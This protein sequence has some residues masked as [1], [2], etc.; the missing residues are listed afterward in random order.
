MQAQRGPFLIL[1]Y[2]ILSYRFLG[3]LWGRS[4]PPERFCMIIIIHPT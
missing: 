3:N 4:G 2:L 1:S